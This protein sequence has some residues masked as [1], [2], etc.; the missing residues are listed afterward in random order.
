MP[1]RQHEQIA[2]FGKGKILYNPQMKAGAI[3]HSKGR[4]KE[5]KN[6][7]YGKFGFV[8]SQKD[9]MK[10]PTS[11]LEFRKP[12]P[13][14]AKHRTEKPVE[15][16]KYLIKTYTNKNDLVLDN[17]M[18][19]GS[20]GVACVETDRCFIGIEIDQ[21]YYSTAEARINEALRQK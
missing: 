16:L 19:S 2:V 21:N 17:C 15:L 11:I 6:D 10:Y 4:P 18:G 7:N 1:L 9:G 13:S 3:N 12:H 8:E 20:T 14:I 5:T